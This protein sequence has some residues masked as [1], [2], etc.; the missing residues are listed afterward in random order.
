MAHRTGPAI[1]HLTDMNFTELQCM[2]F[3]ARSTNELLVAGIQ[4]QMFKIDVETGQIIDMVRNLT[5]RNAKSAL[6]EI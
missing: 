3:T 6:R 1:W 4:D 2:S 5:T